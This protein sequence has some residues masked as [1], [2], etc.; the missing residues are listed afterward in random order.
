MNCKQELLKKLK[1]LSE[2]GVGGEKVNAR[3]KLA[4]LMRKYNITEDDLDDDTL[5]ECE[6]KYK[7]DVEKTL[8]IQTI[9]KVTNEFNMY[10]FT[11]CRTGRTIKRLI[12]C[13]CTKSQKIEI[14]FLFDFYKRVY[15]KDVKLFLESFIQ[16]HCIFGKL[17]DGEKADAPDSETL[18][19]MQILQS[20]MSDETPVRQIERC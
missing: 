15:E 1:A 19:R 16:K 3:R 6:F 12:G 8:L 5:V 7:T 10:G 20:A 17:K 9:Y 18:R 2:Q 14:E 4:E 13:E 11:N